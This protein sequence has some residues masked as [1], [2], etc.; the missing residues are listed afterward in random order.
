[1]QPETFR[2]ND[3]VLSLSFIPNLTFTHMFYCS[4]ATIAKTMGLPIRLVA[5]TNVNDFMCVM[6]EKG[7]LRVGE[8][9]QQTLAS[10]MDIQV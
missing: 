3:G 7:E 2:V 9:A 5:C 4:A 8:R 1:M 6:I 10:A